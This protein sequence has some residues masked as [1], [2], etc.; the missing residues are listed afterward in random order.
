MDKSTL[1]GLF[2]FTIFIGIVAIF[3]VGL[4]K[5]NEAINVCSQVKCPNELSP[6]SVMLFDGITKCIC[7]VEPQN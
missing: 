6:E 1:T 5:Q 3:L 7:I 4:F 2:C